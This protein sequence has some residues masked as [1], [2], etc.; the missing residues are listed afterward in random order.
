MPP[1]T[2]KLAA[3]VELPK[4]ITFVPTMLALNA[5]T[6]CVIVAFTCA[7]HPFPSVTVNV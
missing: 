2:V 3:P 1:E 5:A 6:G 4:Q 7:V